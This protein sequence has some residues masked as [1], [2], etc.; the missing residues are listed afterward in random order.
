MAVVEASE[1]ALVTLR[2]TVVVVAVLN[3]PDIT[4]EL[5]AV[6]VIVSPYSK[7]ICV[8]VAPPRSV[9]R[10]EILSTPPPVVLMEPDVV[11]EVPMVVAA[12]WAMP[13]LTKTIASPIATVRPI[14]PSFR[15][16]LIR[17]I[18][19]FIMQA[20]KKTQASLILKCTASIP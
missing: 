6:F 8:V 1:L 2:P 9:A 10:P 3:V 4:V 16:I 19:I 7:V 14:P 15:Y 13:A 11:T 18:I 20:N 17:F 12:A 5:A